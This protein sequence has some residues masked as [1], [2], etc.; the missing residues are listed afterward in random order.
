[1]FADIA[2]AF[3]FDSLLTGQRVSPSQS[4]LLV[5]VASAVDEDVSD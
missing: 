4:W 5:E 3:A 1:M 2:S